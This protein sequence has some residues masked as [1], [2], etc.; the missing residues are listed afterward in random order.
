MRS[1]RSYL[2]VLG[3][4][5]ALGLSGCQSTD[6]PT[7]DASSPTATR[8][9]GSESPTATPTGPPP[10]FH[11][12]RDSLTISDNERYH[13]THPGVVFE[14]ESAELGP[15]TG[16]FEVENAETG[17]TLAVVPSDSITLGKEAPVR[18]L[19]YGADGSPA[20]TPKLIQNV[21]TRERYPVR[22]SGSVSDVFGQT[23]PPL[24]IRYLSDGETRYETGTRRVVVGYSGLLQQSGT[25]GE[26]R[27]WVPRQGLPRDLSVDG[28][29][30]HE[31]RDPVTFGLSYDP[32]P[33]RFATTVDAADLESGSYDWTVEFGFENRTLLHFGSRWGGREFEA[34]PEIE[35]SE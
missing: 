17:A 4:L 13:S 24:R 21:D 27:L 6:D 25:S 35:I 31:D 3:A 11:H 23:A 22:V 12:Y 16:R 20:D 15:S 19:L 14:E 32:S 9:R 7:T 26:V 34:I 1:R 10:A 28:E 29:L 18:M 2:G 8:P 30:V 5:S 33:D